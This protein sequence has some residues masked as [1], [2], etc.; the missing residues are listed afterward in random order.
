LNHWADLISSA[1]ADKLKETDLL[2]DFLTDIFV[3]LPDYTR[4]TKNADP[5]TIRSRDIPVAVHPSE[6]LS[7]NHAIGFEI[8]RSTAGSGKLLV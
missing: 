7:R 2:P 3:N 4:P 1:Q 6:E 8:W 5:K